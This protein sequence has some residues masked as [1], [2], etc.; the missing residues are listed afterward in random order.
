MGK[1]Y[2]RIDDRLIH[3]QIVTAWCGH[4]KIQEIVAIDDTLAKNTMLQ[5]IMLM[6]IP[7]QYKSHVVTMAQAKELFAQESEGNRLF[8]TRFPQDLANLREELKTCE[9]V[10]IG[11]A[12][13]RPDTKLNLTK[14]GG[15]VFFASEAD[16]VLFDAI[17]ADGVKLVYQTVPKSPAK[18]WP[19]IRKGIKL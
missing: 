9:L 12:A 19:E 1:N 14:G 3:G 2:L 16:V 5:S 15:S 10:V 11:N 17:S 7:K 6:G 4:L 8:V 18:E 13:K